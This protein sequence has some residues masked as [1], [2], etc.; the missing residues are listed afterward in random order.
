MNDSSEFATKITAMAAI[1]SLKRMLIAASV[2]WTRLCLEP[3]APTGPIV[4]QDVPES[5]YGV[6]A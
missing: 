5:Y 3:V 6:N 4:P 2:V 1:V